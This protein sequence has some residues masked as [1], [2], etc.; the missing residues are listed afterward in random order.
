MKVKDFIENYIG[1]NTLI[2]LWYKAD[3]M[4]HVEVIKGD[5]PMMEHELLRSKYKNHEV[6]Y[7]TD[8]LY[9]KSNYQEAVNLVIVKKVEPRYGVNTVLFTKDGRKMGN[10]I[11]IENNDDGKNFVKSDYGNILELSNEEI[12]HYFHKPTN[13]KPSSIK[14]HKHTVK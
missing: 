5:K 1:H 4:G 2:R 14:D 8:I 6:F 12:E 10:V 7:I 11:V 13:D 9:I 3:P